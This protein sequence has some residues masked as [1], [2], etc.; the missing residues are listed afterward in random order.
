MKAREAERVRIAIQKL[1]IAHINVF[2]FGA[3]ELMGS[4]LATPQ[5]KEQVGRDLKA[6]C[7]ELELS[8]I[9]TE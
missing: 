4:P 8:L 3:G 7:T 9:T 1:I 6:A 2:D 5:M